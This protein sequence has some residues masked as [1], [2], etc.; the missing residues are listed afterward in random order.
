MP[1]SI[2]FGHFLLIKFPS[3]ISLDYSSALYQNEIGFISICTWYYFL[4]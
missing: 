3:T 1:G 4:Q 2:G